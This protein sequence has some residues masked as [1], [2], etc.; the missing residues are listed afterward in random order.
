MVGSLLRV[1]EVYSNG[2]EECE[3]SA[4]SQADTIAGALWKWG[5]AAEETAGPIV[6]R[7]IIPLQA[8]H[9]P[10][11]RLSLLAVEDRAHRHA[12]LRGKDLRVDPLSLV[13]SL[14]S[15]PQSYIG[16]LYSPRFIDLS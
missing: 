7:A 15:H 2:N 5:D 8:K 14:S 6:G 9:V 11:R 13:F 12:L 1:G 10:I 16:L 4:N 3:P